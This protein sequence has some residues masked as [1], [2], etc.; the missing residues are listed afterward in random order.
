MSELII[1]G[2]PTC[3]HTKRALQA[4]P[5][6]MFVDVLASAENMNT[7]LALSEGQRRV[8]VIVRDGKAEIG[9]RGGS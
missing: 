8:P 6:A 1:Y 7:M 5:E 4:Y 3:P 9:Y 2:K